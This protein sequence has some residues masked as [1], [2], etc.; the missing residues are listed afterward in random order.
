MIYGYGESWGY[1][2]DRIKP[3]ISDK[4]LSQC[5]IVHYKSHID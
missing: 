4:N 5:H 1:D 2:I 3:K